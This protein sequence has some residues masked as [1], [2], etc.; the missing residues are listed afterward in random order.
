M[1][2]GD[3]ELDPK[4]KRVIFIAPGRQNLTQTYLKYFPSLKSFVC[5]N[6]HAE[7][8]PIFY[9]W[10]DVFHISCVFIR[11][12]S[13]FAPC[14]IPEHR[15]DGAPGCAAD[16]LPD[17][18]KSRSISTR[19]T[20]TDECRDNAK[21]WTIP[22]PNTW[23]L[24]DRSRLHD[25]ALQILLPLLVILPISRNSSDENIHLIISRKHHGRNFYV[26][27]FS[28]HDECQ[29]LKCSKDIYHVICWYLFYFGV[30]LSCTMKLW[31]ST[32]LPR[33]RPESWLTSP[34]WSCFA[35]SRD[36]ANLL[37]PKCNT[38]CHYSA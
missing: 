14:S 26:R 18:A 34:G 4:Y 11:G 17:N 7:F 38:L 36:T 35:R 27:H 20:W 8:L 32:S 37:T 9:K 1:R 6:T 21:S 25:A 19:S 22:A 23:V 31:G 30:F 10:L 13:V 2:N 28:R 16:E 15:P 24:M 29:E 5:V 33:Y 12:T 3:I